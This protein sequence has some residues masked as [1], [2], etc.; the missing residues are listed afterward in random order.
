MTITTALV[1]LAC[2]GGGDANDGVPSDSGAGDPQALVEPL[3]IDF[4]TLPLDSSAD[5]EGSFTI[6]NVG[7]GVLLIQELAVLGESSPFAV[8]SLPSSSI[9]SGEAIPVGLGYGPLTPG[10]HS[11]TVLLRTNDP[12]QPEISIA[13][14]G[15]A[16]GPQLTLAPASDVAFGDIP[17]GCDASAA[18]TMTNTGTGPLEI[19]AVQL[20]GDAAFALDLMPTENGTLPW[21]LAPSGSVS[22]QVAY[23]PTTEDSVTAELRVNSDD[24]VHEAVER[25]FSGTGTT[26]GLVEDT[27]R[28]AA[29]VDFLFLVDAGSGTSGYLTQLRGD[30]AYLTDQLRRENAAY[31]VAAVVAE[32][33]CVLGDPL[34]FDETTPS[35][36]QLSIF[37]AQTTGSSHSLSDELFSLGELALSETGT[38]GCN[39]GLL[40]DPAALG[41]VLLSA[42]DDQSSDTTSDALA[43]LEA[44]LDRPSQLL[45][46]GLVGDAPNGCESATGAVRYTQAIERNG[47]EVGSICAGDYGGTLRNIADATTLRARTIFP[48]SQAPVPSSIVVQLRG[49]ERDTGWTYIAEEQV[50]RFEDNIAPVVGDSVIVSYAPLPDTCE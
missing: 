39:E 20:T 50:L 22:V 3:S 11:D 29:D 2:T 36:T 24:P 15:Q 23:T 44:Q 30:L 4:G 9:A 21:T 32:D 37:A 27:F 13:L 6:R 31:R 18:V 10:V 19:G 17:L 35:N 14:T 49:V 28:T 8:V 46:H 33:G 26:S 42:R 40:R 48:L 45:L 12:D 41:V 5:A 43:A 34:F 25:A 7:R 16:E 38:G 47:G 1:L